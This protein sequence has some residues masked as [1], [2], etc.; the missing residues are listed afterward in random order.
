MTFVEAKLENSR[1]KHGKYLMRK[2]EA[3]V[4]TVRD[5]PETSQGSAKG[6][7]LEVMLRGGCGCWLCVA[8]PIYHPT[9]STT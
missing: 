6:Q 4:V 7:A 8:P 1:L 3:V 2:V 5:T 9:A